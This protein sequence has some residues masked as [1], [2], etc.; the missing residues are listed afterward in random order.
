MPGDRPMSP[1]MTVLPVFVM[2]EPAMTAYGV[3]DPRLMG[4]T[5]KAGVPVTATIV[6]TPSS[7]TPSA[8]RPLR[9]LYRWR[10]A[11]S[12][13][14][15]RGKVPKGEAERFVAGIVRIR[16]PALETELSSTSTRLKTGFC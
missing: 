12:A 9:A 5:A 7:P 1:V 4:V 6:T 3:A 16:T 8:F 15:T 2:V 14:K 13:A 11:L 10:G